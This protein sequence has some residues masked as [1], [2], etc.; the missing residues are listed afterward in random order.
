M[1]YRNLHYHQ[2]Y[3]FGDIL[4]KSHE[5]RTSVIDSVSST[6]KICIFHAVLQCFAVDKIESFVTFKS[7][8]KNNVASLI[9]LQST[10]FFL[11]MEP[12]Y[13]VLISAN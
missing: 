8:V 10:S 3:S 5:N 2:K 12:I 13:I 11:H 4:R 7:V 9:K 1:I 6:P